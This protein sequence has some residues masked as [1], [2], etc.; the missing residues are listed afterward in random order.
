MLADNVVY[1]TVSLYTGTLS[2]AVAVWILEVSDNLVTNR[3]NS[4][5]P[6]YILTFKME[7]IT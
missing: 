7:V 6:K 5:Q 3:L 4:A 2:V 1:I